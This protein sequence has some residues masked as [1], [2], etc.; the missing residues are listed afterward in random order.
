MAAEKNA[1]RDIP[2]W[3]VAGLIL[4]GGIY[5]FVFFEGQVMDL[6]RIVGLLAVIAVAIVVAS[7][8]QKGGEFFSYVREVDVERRKVVWPTRQETL[9]TTL[10]VL[11]ITV[12]V[13]LIL[14]AMDTL[15]GFAVRRLIG[16]GGEL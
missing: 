9:Q 10:I 6:L 13:G 5:G 7:R 15:F 12:I 3:I 11:V 16:L 8:T 1:T 4:A 14:F 2:L